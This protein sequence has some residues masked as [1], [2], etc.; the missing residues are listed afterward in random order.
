M[1][2]SKKQYRAKMRAQHGDDWW[3]KA[4]KKAKKPTK[5]A[6][7][8]KSEWPQLIG[9]VFDATFFTDQPG[10]CY[11]DAMSSDDYA[12]SICLEKRGGRFRLYEPGGMFEEGD[13]ETEVGTFTKKEALAYL[14]KAAKEQVKGH[15]KYGTYW[16]VAERMERAYGPQ[17]PVK[18]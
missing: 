17:G 13:P 18:W 11:Q 15:K 6:V 9:G 1:A 3:K 5:K 2:E 12:H 16:D 7:K 14:R 10:L 4:K 8:G